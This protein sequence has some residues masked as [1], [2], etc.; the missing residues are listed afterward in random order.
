MVGLKVERKSVIVGCAKRW[1]QLKDTWI[2]ER[3]QPTDAEDAK[4][5]HGPGE[6]IRKTEDRRVCRNNKHGCRL[7]TYIFR[8]QMR[9]TFR[10][11]MQP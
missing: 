10:I 6:E 2:D 8:S 9:M 4:R 5:R 1:A 3:L 11:R 7:Y